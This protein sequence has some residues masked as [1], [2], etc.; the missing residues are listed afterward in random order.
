M[1]D[2]N[3][4]TLTEQEKNLAVECSEQYM[5]ALTQEEID[6]LGIDKELVKTM[7]EE[8]ILYNKVE[9]ELT[10][11]KVEQISDN[12]ARIMQANMIVLTKESTAKKVLK[13]AKAGD[14]FEELAKKYSQEE[15]IQYSIYRG[16]ISDDFSSKVFELTTGD[17]SDIIEADG[18]YYIVYCIED[19]DKDA[20]T[21]H[22]LE[23]EKTKRK[24]VFDELYADY[25]EKLSSQFNKS[26]WKSLD[27][28]EIPSV[29]EADFFKIYEDL[30]EE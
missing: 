5:E 30:L 21:A 14:D 29:S 2:D 24:E 8:Y 7:Y 20:T 4:V 27:I 25:V 17:L 23:L 28:E 19:Y 3:Q 26:V 1:A 13:K 6:S 18:K 10:N 11:D 16:M 22:K 15:Q 9:T 12:D